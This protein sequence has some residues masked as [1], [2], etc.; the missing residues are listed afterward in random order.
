MGSASSTGL[1][2]SPNAGPLPRSPSRLAQQGAGGQAVSQTFDLPSDSY[3]PRRGP[4]DGAFCASPVSP[5]ARGSPN[6]ADSALTAARSGSA[7]PGTPVAAAALAVAKAL[8]PHTQ[9]QLA[10]A[11]RSLH[12]P[13]PCEMSPSAAAGFYAA[14]F[15]F[16]RMAHPAASAAQAAAGEAHSA[17]AAAAAAVLGRGRGGSP[18]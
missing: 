17:A 18:H 14:C 6:R 7:R 15:E 10:A 9:A 4:I 11:A 5:A 16:F 1:A 2:A 3:T 13:D 8:P 12:L